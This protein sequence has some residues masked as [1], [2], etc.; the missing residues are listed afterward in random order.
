MHQGA[1]KQSLCIQG[2]LLLCLRDAAQDLLGF[3]GLAVAAQSCRSFVL[4]RGCKPVASKVPLDLSD[5]LVQIHLCSATVN[6]S[7][8]MASRESS[9]RFGHK[10]VRNCTDLKTLCASRSTSEWKKTSLVLKTGGSLFSDTKS[11]MA[12][13]AALYM[14]RAC[15]LREMTTGGCSTH[16]E[17]I[18]S[19]QSWMSLLLALNSCWS[20]VGFSDNDQTCCNRFWK[21][22]T[23]GCTTSSTTSVWPATFS[24][25][26]YWVR[27]K[28]PLPVVGASG[29]PCVQVFNLVTAMKWMPDSRSD[30]F[31]SKVLAASSDVT[32]HLP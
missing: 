28:L 29:S 20:C 3:R 17:C 19:C 11:V 26:L 24:K 15:P 2:R 30:I 22:C 4:F 14:L 32:P 7:K 5:P 16:L 31:V 12:C 21:P 27:L 8:D 9:G 18:Q 6:S 13:L 10:V 25:K 23:L 1:E